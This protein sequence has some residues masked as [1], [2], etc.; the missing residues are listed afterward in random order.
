MPSKFTVV[1]DD[2]YVKIKRGQETICGGVAVTDGPG[3]RSLRQ[4]AF[5]KDEYRK[6]NRTRIAAMKALKDAGWK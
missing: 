3:F 5:A 4:I 2:G 6:N 1:E